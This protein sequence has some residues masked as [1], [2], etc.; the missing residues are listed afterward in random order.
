MQRKT[1]HVSSEKNLGY[2]RENIHTSHFSDSNKDA[3]VVFKQLNGG[4]ENDYNMGNI[5]FDGP[6]SISSWNPPY[7]AAVYAIMMKSNPINRPET[8][9]ILYFGE[10]SNLSERG[11]LRSHHKYH[12]FLQ[13]AGSESNLYIGIHLMPESTLAQRQYVESNLI[14]QFKLPC[15]D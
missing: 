4:D 13:C 1:K 5:E 14:R 7:R 9:S 6:Y 11:F 2:G 15:N 12:C 3:F 10:S 8:Y